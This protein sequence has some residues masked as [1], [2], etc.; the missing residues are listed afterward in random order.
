MIE[1]KEKRGAGE[2]LLNSVDHDGM[3]DGYDVELVK[4]IAVAV[5]IPVIA[6]GGAGELKH[7]IE[8][9]T[10]VTNLGG[11]AA[12]AIYYWTNITPYDVSRYLASN[13]IH[14]RCPERQTHINY[15]RYLGYI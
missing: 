5:K 13:N 9:A 11:M 14:V 3:R 6:A 1:R 7:F 2:I 15:R 10:A 4:K 8:L 12:G